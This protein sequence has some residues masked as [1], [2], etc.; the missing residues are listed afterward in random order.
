[1][2]VIDGFKSLLKSRL[3]ATVYEIDVGESEVVFEVV[4]SGNTFR[5]FAQLPENFPASKMSVS[6]I[7]RDDFPVMD[8]VYP[9]FICFGNED[10][11]ILDRYNPAAAATDII[12]RCLN[13]MERSLSTK[14]HSDSLNEYESWWALLEGAQRSYCAFNSISEARFVNT[15]RKDSVKLVY[16]EGFVPP[17]DYLL[18]EMFRGDHE[19]DVI[20]PI[21]LP[22]LDYS[23]KKV[24]IELLQS[25]WEF[26]G[27]KESVINLVAQLG[28]R[29]SF[30]I[31]FQVAKPSGGFTYIGFD[32]S[33]EEEAVHPL[34]ESSSGWG[35][36][37][38]VF[39]RID[40]DFVSWRGGGDKNLQSK[41]VAI[42]G[43]GSLG[44]LIVSQLA[45]A[46]VGHLTLCDHETF[47]VPNIMRHVLSTTYL[48]WNK[49]EAL[50][51]FIGTTCPYS[52]LEVFKEKSQAI[53]KEEFFQRYD[54]IIF[55]TGDLNAELHANEHLCRSNT[56]TKAIFV[57]QEAYGVGGHS[58]HVNYEKPGCLECFFTYDG[59]F[60]PYPI[61]NLLEP[62]QSF[63]VSN[64]GC[65]GIF[66]PYSY[67]DAC[68][69]ALQATEQALSA[70]S[71]SEYE[72]K[73]SSWKHQ[74]DPPSNCRVS[75]R[76]GQF[77]GYKEEQVDYI[78]R[79]CKVCRENS[80]QTE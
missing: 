34:C 77:D 29:R 22:H 2:K 78:G 71:N 59:V 76:Y 33:S 4:R 12:E 67:V 7:N 5:L 52:E 6:L 58:I 16:Q 31:V 17:N 73:L 24:S 80:P 32:C 68:K 79:A 42:F 20:I 27:C 25:I 15:V 37:P 14:D 45:H 18:A 69:T 51:H 38:L 19:L 50:S 21:E 28:K 26:C 75:A 56:N 64:G 47:N 44:G 60:K 61:F 8:H 36:T 41:R 55:A 62:N 13:E 74:N 48:Q 43:C 57:S 40:A 70:L 66:S 39:E 72:F 53:F 65:S 11:L 54:L 63:T 9:N 23:K 49:A 10:N 3:N 1:M 35:F 46:G 30:T